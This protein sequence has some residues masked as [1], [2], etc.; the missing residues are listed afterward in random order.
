MATNNVLERNGAVVATLRIPS[1]V[2]A[3]DDLHDR[4][5]LDHH[6]DRRVKRRHDDFQ[7]R[8]GQQAQRAAGPAPRRPIEDRHDEPHEFR[9]QQHRHREAE[10]RQR[11]FRVEARPRRKQTELVGEIF[12]PDIGRLQHQHD[13]DDELRHP[14]GRGEIAHDARG[15]MLPRGELEALGG[16]N[17]DVLQVALTPAPVARGE[18]DERWRAFLEAAAKRRQHVDRV[19]RATDH[20]RLDEVMAENVPAEGRTSAQIRQATVIGEGARADDG[21]MAP[22]IAVAARPERQPRRDDGAVDARRELLHAREHRVAI[23]DERQRLDDARVGIG[24][25][26]VGERDDGVS[27]HQAVGVEHDHVRVG[28]APAG[29]EIGDIA[30]LAARVFRASSIIDAR[31]GAEPRA[32]G[33]KGAFLRDPNIGVG[34]VRQEEPVEGRA[35]AGRLDI[36]VNRLQGAKHA[37]RRLVI[38]RHDDGGSLARRHGRVDLPPAARQQPDK[39]DDGAR[40]RQRDPRKV[41]HEQNEQRPFERRD[42]ADVHDAI[43]FVRAVNGEGEAA[44]KHDQARQP[45]WRATRWRVHAG[46]VEPRQRLRR[47]GQRRLGRRGRQSIQ[48]RRRGRVGH[49]VHRY[50]QISLRRLPPASR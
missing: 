50:S 24:L 43:H 3:K 32:H 11:A 8:R 21:V 5:G 42:R 44:A 4:A 39:A 34:R 49:G 19:A 48:L 15:E 40:E 22:V 2:A 18:I 41:R 28:A 36:L 20:R 25:H 1:G 38:D 12:R 14:E 33:E 23:D 9:R 45:R 7:Q 30:R 46:R 27:G 29:H 47:H 35:R 37:R 16:Q 26:R 31:A 6:H 13:A 17:A 10:Q